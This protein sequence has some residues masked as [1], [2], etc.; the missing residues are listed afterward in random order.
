MSPRWTLLLALLVTGCCQPK[1]VLQR[2]PVAVPCPQAPYLAYPDLPISHLTPASKPD[3]VAKAYV[4]T[5]EILQSSL[6]QALRILD[7]Y[8][9]PPTKVDK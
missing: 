6:K 2:V 1:V 4:F 7:G 9:V 8:R 5:V 3:E